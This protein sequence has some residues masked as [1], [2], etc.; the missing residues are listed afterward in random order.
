M[1]IFFVFFHRPFVPS[2]LVLRLA[3][4][5]ERAAFNPVLPI[6]IVLKQVAECVARCRQFYKARYRDR[7]PVESHLAHSLLRILHRPVVLAHVAIVQGNLCLI[8]GL[9][10]ETGVHHRELEVTVV[11]HCLSFLKLLM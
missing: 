7:F 11:N 1:N 2:L 5:P 8:L 4:V 10:A 9:I 6:P 3:P